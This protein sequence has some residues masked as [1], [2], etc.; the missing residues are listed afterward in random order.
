MLKW[1][2]EKTE[3]YIEYEAAARKFMLE[4]DQKDLGK[5]PIMSFLVD[6]SDIIKKMAEEQSKDSPF[7]VEHPEDLRVTG[8]P[9]VVFHGLGET[10][11]IDRNT[12]FMDMIRR[13]T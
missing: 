3:R 1:Y 4:S 12:Q 8:I 11:Q 2:Q 9:T 7:Y 10:C 13:G 5:C 6:E